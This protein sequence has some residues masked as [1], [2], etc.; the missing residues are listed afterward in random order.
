MSLLL[1]SSAVRFFADAVVGIYIPLYLF[2]LQ[3]PIEK[4]M[5]FFFFHALVQFIF[6]PISA[7]FSSLMGYKKLMIASIPVF[8]LFYFSLFLV[9]DDPS[10]LY[11]LAA[12]RGMA[13]ALFWVPFH[14]Y[15]TL[16]G[17]AERRG[18]E[19]AIFSIF[20]WV[21]TIPGPMIG[22][23]L[24]VWYGFDAM[25]AFT[26]AALVLSAFPLLINP[27]VVKP[28]RFSL[29]K[30]FSRFRKGIF[31]TLFGRSF[32]DYVQ[33]AVWPIFMYLAIGSYLSFGWINTVGAAVFIIIS[34]IAGNLFDRREGEKAFIMGTSLV[35]I[36]WVIR[37][38]LRTFWQFLLLEVVYRI[39]D[40]LRFTNLEALFYDNASKSEDIMQFTVIRELSLHIGSM[41]CSLLSYIIYV[42]TSNLALTFLLASLGGAIQLFAKKDFPK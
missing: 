20:S 40:T 21:S 36:L 11:P 24:I 2:S 39:P 34:W 26:A 28:V 10:L 15:F 5:L 29:R 8:V 38:Y 12:L 30:A 17:T 19:Y 33:Y 13:F 6:T 1:L 9:G 41:A 22:A 25:F 4:I 3:F 23:L 37:M 27:D 42:N 7:K 16:S 35:S 18:K 14:T 31:V 32:T